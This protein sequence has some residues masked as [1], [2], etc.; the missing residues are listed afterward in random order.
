MGP[1]FRQDD[2]E[3]VAAIR[4]STS[5]YD[6]A[7]SRHGL[8]EVCV[9]TVPREEREQGMPGARCTRGLVCRVAQKKAHTSIQV[10]RR[11]S[12][13]PCAMVLRLMRCS[14]RRANSSCHRRCR[15]DGFRS[16]WIVSATDS[17][18]PA[19]GARTT[20]FCRTREAPFVL[21]DAK[22]LTAEPPCE[23]T[24]TPTPPRPPHPN[25][26]FVTTADRPSVGGTN[27]G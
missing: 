8:P 15:L 3:C 25:P 18:T 4:V 27:R 14:P 22:S 6:F 17:L 11:H 13:I 9:D 16:G 20:R 10:Q 5:K 2:S 26:R 12:G 23:Q 7:F 19:T 21:R 1:G 24:F